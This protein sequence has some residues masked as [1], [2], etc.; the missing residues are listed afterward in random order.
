MFLRCSYFF[1]NLSLDVLIN[2]VLKQSNACSPSS[3][4]HSCRYHGELRVGHILRSAPH[5]QRGHEHLRRL[6]GHRAIVGIL[7]RKSLL[8]GVLDNNVRRSS[9]DRDSGSVDLADE[10]EW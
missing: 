7:L 10:E 4:F 6:F 8:V 1:Q 3:K 2:K 9:D 5:H